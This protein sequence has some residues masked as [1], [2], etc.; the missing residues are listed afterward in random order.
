MAREFGQSDAEVNAS[1]PSCSRCSLPAAV[2]LRL[3]NPADGAHWDGGDALVDAPGFILKEYLSG[4]TSGDHCD[5]YDRNQALDAM[6]PDYVAHNL[7]K[8]T[9][10]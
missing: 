3:L 9:R 4:D 2:L 10:K 8:K 1:F 6:E 5:A 7:K